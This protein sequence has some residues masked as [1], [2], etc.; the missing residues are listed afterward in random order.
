M[1]GLK[2][3]PKCSWRNQARGTGLRDVGERDYLDGK[4]T[5]AKALPGIMF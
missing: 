2:T 5:T 4:K 3:I 1:A